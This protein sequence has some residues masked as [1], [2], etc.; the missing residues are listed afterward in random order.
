MH[1]DSSSYSLRHRKPNPGS[2][3][4][5]SAGFVHAVKTVKESVQIIYIR[6]SACIRH[7]YAYFP[8][9]VADIQTD[10]P[11]CLGIFYRVIKQN[12]YQLLYGIAVS[13]IL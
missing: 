13:I 3:C 7:L 11:A 10:F 8:P 12:G 9:P 4:M 2:S 6:H 5:G 1:T